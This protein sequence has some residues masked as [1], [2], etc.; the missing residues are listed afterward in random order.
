MCD[1]ADKRSAQ[2]AND[3]QVVIVVGSGRSGTSV[4]ASVLRELGYAVPGPE[5]KP[6]STNPRG[7]AEPQWLVDFHTEQLKH[8]GVHASD[9]RPAAWAYT[10]EACLSTTVIESARMWL[11]PH[12]ADS[13]HIV[14]KDPWILWFTTLWEGVARDLGAR[15]TYITMLRA[16]ADVVR[17]K[18]HW[19]SMDLTPTNRAAGWVNTMV[20]AERATRGKERAFV[21]FDDLISDWAAT[22]GAVNDRVALPPVTTA[23]THMV[24]AADKILD[25]SLV[26]SVGSWDQLEVWPPIADLAGRVW[27][28]LTD[29]LGAEREDTH[30]QLDALR[31]EFRTL[32]AAT[33]QVAE[34]TIRAA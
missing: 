19:Y 23:R 12:F 28:A 25:Q 16:P 5:V 29:L 32:Y 11:A 24:A 34:S 3:R 13:D 1:G 20:F 18:N 7:F 17:S 22:I 14:L 27:L 2:V 6:D 8:A 26:R 30:T 10:T 31:A 15:T 4:V 9:A 33:E 21:A